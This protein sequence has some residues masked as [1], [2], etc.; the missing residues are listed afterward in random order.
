EIPSNTPPHGID[1]RRVAAISLYWSRTQLLGSN[2]APARGP[3]HFGVCLRRKL[4]AKSESQTFLAS[5][6]IGFALRRVPSFPPGDSRVMRLSLGQRA[7]G[8]RCVAIC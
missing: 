5:T 8:R 3:Q 1:Q 6:I 4:S 7:D 2:S